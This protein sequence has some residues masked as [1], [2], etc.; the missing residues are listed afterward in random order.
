MRILITTTQDRFFLS[1]ILGRAAYFKNQGNVIAVA[2]QKTSADL[3]RKIE[4]AGFVFYDTGIERQSLNPVTQIIALINLFRIHQDFRPDVSYHLGAKSIFY[5]TF[6]GRLYNSK[7][8][9]VNAP[10]GLGFVFASKTFKAKLLRPIVLFLYKLFL[11]PTRSRVIVENFDDIHFFIENGCL[12]PQDS[13]CILGAG[14]DTDV[15]CPIPFEE[16][17]EICTVV[18]ASRLIKEKG[19]WDFVSVA[20]KL[21]QL[22]V[23]VRMQLVGEPDFG[24]PSSI[25]KEDYQGLCLNNEIEYLGY[26]SNMVPV[27]QKAH[28]CCLPSYYREGLPKILIEAAS[29]GLVI[30]TTDA[31]GCKEAVRDNNGFL[32]RAHDI[33]KISELIQILVKN[34]Q[35]MRQLAQNSR[36]VAK[37]YFDATLINKRTYDLIKGLFN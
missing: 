32:F 9:I 12:R 33:E 17:N 8:A 24:N 21:K 34:P 23:P 14:V 11:N 37:T 4:L 35:E 28:I 22:G 31:I 5:G 3:V 25:T 27:L 16:R 26:T 30:L 6:I 13:F 15:F 18:M 10:I 20:H 29:V 19:V 1:H 36:R 2:A 7:V